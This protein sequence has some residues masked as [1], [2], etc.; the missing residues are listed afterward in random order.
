MGALQLPPTQESP[1]DM[2]AQQNSAWRQFYEDAWAA[3]AAFLRS[4]IAAGENNPYRLVKLLQAHERKHQIVHD[5]EHYR[6]ERLPFPKE[7]RDCPGGVPVL[8]HSSF[9]GQPIAVPYHATDNLH[10]FIVDFIDES[11]P[12]DCIVELGCGYGRNLFEIFYNGGPRQAR[13]FGGELTE[14]GVALAQE[15]AALAPEMDAT[16][17]RFDYLNPDF[18]A[19]PRVDRALVFTMHS[20]EQVRRIEPSLFDAIAGAARH[21]TCIHLEPFGFQLADLGPMSKK[22]RE[23]MVENDWNL[24]FGEAL[25]RARDEFAINIKYVATEIYLPMHAENPTS[26]A[27]WERG[28]PEP[29]STQAAPTP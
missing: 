29:P 18:S 14:S 8:R 6:Y 27:I 15:L 2:I 16:F 24:N 1:A 4:K 19:L 12:F 13:Y 25:V 21:V 10:N 11:G 28:T 17:F 26:L 5:G 22:H 7:V 20:I 23:F 9:R 3:R